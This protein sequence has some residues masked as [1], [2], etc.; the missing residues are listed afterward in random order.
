L[1]KVIKLTF[2]SNLD[3]VTDAIRS[4]EKRSGRPEGSVK[5]VAVSK[6]VD[7]QAIK[8]MNRAGQR[9]FAE[10][11]PQML[12]D[13]ARS[14]AGENIAWHFIG[15]LQSNKIKYVY[16]VAELVHSIDRVDLLEQFISWAQKTGRK[17][18]CLLEVH[19]SEEESKQGFAADEVLAVIDKY[20]NSEHLDIV[21][22][23]GMA[24]FVAEQEVIR[25]CFKKL[26]GIFAESKKHEGIAYH[27]R[28]ISM[29]MSN[30]FEIAVEE[31]ATLVRV[32]TALFAGESQ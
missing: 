6:T 13:K 30:D 23:M 18:P 25:A 1:S 2:K 3:K 28:E 5:L 15:P 14:L 11:R 32:G 31:G 20:K 27:A 4:A 17:C 22:L 29:G 19:I 10:G 24:P 8:E 12:R 21:G 26:A 9:V 16:P 7:E